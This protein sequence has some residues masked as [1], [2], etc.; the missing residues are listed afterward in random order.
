VWFS[1]DGL[2][3]F[4]TTRSQSDGR[5]LMY[6]NLNDEEPGVRSSGLVLRHADSDFNVTHEGDRIAIVEERTTAVYDV[7]TGD[8]LA[9][10]VINGE[11]SPNYCWFDGPDTV[12]IPASTPVVWNGNDADYRSREYRFDVVSKTLTHGEEKPR[13]RW[14]RPD[15]TVVDNRRRVTRVEKDTGDT[16]ALVDAESGEVVADLGAV[17]YQWEVRDLGDGRFFVLRSSDGEGVMDCFDADGVRL[18]RVEYGP[19]SR[20]RFAGE[21]APGRL[22]LGADVW[23]PD[24]SKVAGHRFSIVNTETGVAETTVDGFYPLQRRY[25][26][27]IEAVGSGAWQVGSV[28]S[29]LLKAEDGSLHLLDP[30]TGQLKQLIPTA[31]SV[32]AGARTADL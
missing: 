20:L 7:E 3:A 2:H 11:F 30:A 15:T 32:S 5:S 9:A 22:V 12:V 4:W 17:Q 26:R 27:E 21:A 13:E 19:D 29:R 31:G 16:L 25:G 1:G 10:V 8:Q 14:Q 24:H 28:A 6:V 18:H 23:E